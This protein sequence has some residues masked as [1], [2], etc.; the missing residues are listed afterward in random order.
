MLKVSRDSAEHVEDHG[1]VTDRHQDGHGYTINFITFNADVDGTPMLKGLPGD[2]CSCPHWGY[3]ISGSIVVRYADGTEEMN[4][5]GD[6]Y[7]WP[8]GHT[9]WTDEGVT[10][11][12]FSPAA[13]LRPVL[14]HIGMQ[15]AHA[16]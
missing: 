8:G 1:L 4:R 3:V 5:A 16:R 6:F 2:Q 15:L 9:G 13:E 12:E 11:V 7:Y 10:F 14:E